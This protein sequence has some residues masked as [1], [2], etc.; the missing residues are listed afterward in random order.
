M[1]ISLII[2]MNFEAI[3]VPF[4]RF[5]NDFRKLQRYGISVSK[6]GYL[7]GLGA[8]KPIMNFYK[9]DVTSE[10]L[11]KV[12]PDHFDRIRIP[13]IWDL[14]T[15]IFGTDNKYYNTEEK[16]RLFS[17]FGAGKSNSIS[18][19][20]P[21]CPN[22]LKKMALYFKRKREHYL[23]DIIGY[24][25]KNGAVNV[26]VYLD[27][28]DYDSITVKNIVDYMKELID[29]FNIYN[30]SELKELGC[31]LHIW[32]S[33]YELPEKRPGAKEELFDVSLSEQY[34]FPVYLKIVDNESGDYRQY[35]DSGHTLPERDSFKIMKFVIEPAIKNFKTIENEISKIK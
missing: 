35:N 8:K 31:G 30:Y 29:K 16:N 27:T 1:N 22:F 26:V 7:S 32:V 13:T 9:G 3:L 19:L 4:M 34:Y 25:H 12:E 23:C 33:C 24:N 20:E 11:W 5:L 18:I 10:L 2:Q 21:T 17:S 6:L 15:K 14:A 28:K